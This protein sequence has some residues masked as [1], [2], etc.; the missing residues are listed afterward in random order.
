M[1]L[2]SDEGG[3]VLRHRQASVTGVSEWAGCKRE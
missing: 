2:Q 3:K 1:L